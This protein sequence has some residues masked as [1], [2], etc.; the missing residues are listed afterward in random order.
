MTGT[1]DEP[2]IKAS[3]DSL[4]EGSLRDIGIPPRP[5]IL[6]R[7]SSEMLREEPDYKRLAT[8]IGADVALSAGL[9]KTA[10]SPFFGYR[11]RAR[12]I[13]EALMLLGLDVASRALAGIILRR[14]FPNSLH[15]ERFWDCLLY[16]SDAADE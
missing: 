10:N 2:Q 9:I 4:M 14:V 11:I 16:T 7:I 8:I 6:E 13:N 1:A 12:T 3:L 5:A 15:L